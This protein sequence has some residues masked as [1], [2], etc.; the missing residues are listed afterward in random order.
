MTVAPRCQK[1]LPYDPKK[2]IAPITMGVIFPNV[3]VVHPG[4]PAKT[5]AEFVALAKAKPG[6]A[7]LRAP[8]ASAAPG[9]SPASSSSSARAST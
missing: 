8:R 4:V 3:F 5:L 1:N 7:H 9:T 2:D 6:R